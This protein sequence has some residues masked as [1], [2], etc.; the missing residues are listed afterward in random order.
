MMKEINLLDHYPRAKRNI[1]ARAQWI[2]TSAEVR[3]TAKRYGKEYFDGTRE[4]GYGGYYYDGR[5][6]PVVERFV[7]YYGLTP[8]SV[9]LDIG[10]GKGFFLHDLQNRIPGIT[11]AGLDISSY[12]KDKAMDSVKPFFTVGNALALPYPDKSFDLVLAINVIHNLKRPAALIAL[13]EIMRV[14]RKNAY[15]QVDSYRN[16]EEKDN[17]DRWQLTAETI[18]DPNGW[19]ELFLEAGYTGD[20]YWTITE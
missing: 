12:A 15:V 14:T 2:A 1:A 9:V 7:H 19:R 16:Q 5:W 8:Q 13:Q 6:I 11:I 3:E 10:C 18:L 20:Y 17:I 4:Q